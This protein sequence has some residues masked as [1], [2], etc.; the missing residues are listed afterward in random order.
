MGTLL[1]FRFT[2]HIFL[3]MNPMGCISSF[4]QDAIV[5]QSISVIVKIYQF[6]M[7]HVFPNLTKK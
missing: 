6:N 5:A 4:G 2:S 7:N 1:V 3:G